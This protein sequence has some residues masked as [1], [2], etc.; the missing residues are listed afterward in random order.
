MPPPRVKLTDAWVVA[1]FIYPKVTAA[2]RAEWKA[3]FDS[4]GH[5]QIT[6]IPRGPPIVLSTNNKFYLPLY[7]G[8]YILCSKKLRCKPLGLLTYLLPAQTERSIQR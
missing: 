8:Y 7:Q 1:L 5:L 6:G 4:N 2:K 3:D